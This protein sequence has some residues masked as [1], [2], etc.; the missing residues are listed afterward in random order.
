VY[1]N[2]EDTDATVAKAQELGGAVMAPAFDAGE[3]GRIA[4]LADPQGGV[5]AVITPGA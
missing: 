2:V 5:F 4:V 1:F 3:V